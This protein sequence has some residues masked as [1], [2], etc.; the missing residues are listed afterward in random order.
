[1]IWLTMPDV[2]F[3]RLAIQLFGVFAE[4]EKAKFEC[5]LNELLPELINLLEPRTDESENRDFDLLLIKVNYTL[6]KIMEHCPVGVKKIEII[7]ITNELWDRIVQ[8]LKHPHVWIRTLSARLV[9]TLLGWHDV[10]DL[11]AHVTNP[12]REISPTYL[13]CPEI[14]AR[15]RSLAS[16]SVE[17][18]QSDMLDNQLADQVMKNLVFIA[19]VTNRIPASV[20]EEDANNTAPTLTWLTGKLRRE[21][22]AEV[23]LRPTVPIKVRYYSNSYF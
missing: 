20:Q 21:I 8:H 11:A 3:K 2:S 12:S 19:K 6:L 14:A 13:L 17:Q 18:L 7:D 16:T 1:M 23:K 15:L 22:N 9:G 10:D 5:R 4:A